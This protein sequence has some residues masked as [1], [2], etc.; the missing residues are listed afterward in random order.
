[1]TLKDH[2]LSNAKSSKERR[3]VHDLLRRARRGDVLARKELALPALLAGVK[4]VGAEARSYIHG[5]PRMEEDSE[6]F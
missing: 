5:L 4:V 3:E 1:M 2:L 6:A